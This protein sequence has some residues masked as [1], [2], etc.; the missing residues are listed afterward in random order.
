MSKYYLVKEI[1]TCYVEY[2]V[3][4]D[5]VKETREKVKILDQDSQQLLNFP[6]YI[7]TNRYEVSQLD[8]DQDDPIIVQAIKL[9]ELNYVEIEPE[10]EKPKRKRRKKFEPKQSATSEID[11]L[12]ALAKPTKET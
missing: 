9:I 1:Q 3:R 2:V 10:E 4:A 8:S 11:E 7:N 6:T 12:A 5:S